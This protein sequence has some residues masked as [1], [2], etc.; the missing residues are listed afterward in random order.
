MASSSID[1]TG[2]PENHFN[3][4]VAH[5]LLPRDSD[6]A[7]LKRLLLELAPEAIKVQLQALGGDCCLLGILVPLYPKTLKCAA[8]QRSAAA[9]TP[10]YAT[11]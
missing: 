9:A 3:W 4:G 5:P 6:V 7:L 10:Q 11:H 8:P 2:W 1:F